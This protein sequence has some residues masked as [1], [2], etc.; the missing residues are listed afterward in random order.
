MLERRGKAFLQIF[1]LAIAVG[2]EASVCAWVG[3]TFFEQ[4][5]G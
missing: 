5:L 4:F 1:I 2:D 3:E